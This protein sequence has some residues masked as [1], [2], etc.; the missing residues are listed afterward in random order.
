MMVRYFMNYHV[1]HFYDN[2]FMQN[3]EIGD[4]YNSN[5]KNNNSRIRW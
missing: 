1:C 4:T 5:N 2:I 3:L